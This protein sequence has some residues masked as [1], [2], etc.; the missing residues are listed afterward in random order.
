A[1]VFREAADGPAMG[2]RLGI[3]DAVPERA[4]DVRVLDMAVTRISA[5]FVCLGTG[6]NELGATTMMTN[7]FN[8]REEILRILEMITGLRMNHAYVRPGGVAQDIPPGTLEAI[9]EADPRI[10]GYIKDLEDLMLAN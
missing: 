6:G 2:K 3:E 10:R 8:G 5:H 7:G 9:R 4:N 1:R